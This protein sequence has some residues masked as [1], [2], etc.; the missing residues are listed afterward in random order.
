MMDIEKT[1]IAILRELQNDGR[2]SSA[3]L[4]QKLSLSEAPCWR[5]IKK[6]ESEGYILGYQ[7]NLDRK[8]LGYSIIAYALVSFG[9]HAGDDPLLF[10]REVQAMPNILQCHNVAGE[11]DYLLM[12]TATSLEQYGDFIWNQLRKMPGVSSVKSLLSMR[13]VKTS[14]KLVF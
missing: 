5:R 12:I 10:E 1:D 9:D 6:L 8:K 4:A 2:L 7:A 11:C 3:K 13:E 14:G